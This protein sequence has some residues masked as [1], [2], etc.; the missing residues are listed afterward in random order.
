[1]DVDVV[2][3]YSYQFL[4]GVLVEVPPKT[5]ALMTN[6]IANYNNPKRYTNYINTIIIIYIIH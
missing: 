3:V 5:A 4:P 6:T 1:M 2:S